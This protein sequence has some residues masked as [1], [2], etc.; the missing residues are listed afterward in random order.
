MVENDKLIRKLDEVKEA[1]EELWIPST[2]DI[3]SK[4]DTII[5]LLEK[6]VK[7]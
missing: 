2:S 7:K 1:V 4:L 5:S 3:E 6:I